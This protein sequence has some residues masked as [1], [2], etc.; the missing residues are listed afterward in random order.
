MIATAISRALLVLA[1]ATPASASDDFSARLDALWDFGDPAASETRF[2]AERAKHATGSREALETETQIARTQGLRRQFAAAHGTL[3]AVEPRLDA[4]DVRVRVRYLLERGRTFNSSGAPERAVPLFS[5][6]ATR[7]AAAGRASDEFYTVDALH[8]LG[9][10]APAADQLGWNLKALA[11]ADAATDPR[12]RGWRGSLLN[13]LGWTYFDAGNV[14]TALDYWRRALAF[15]EAAGNA[16]RIREAKWAV[17]RGL[18]AQGKL[19]EA[20][21]MQRALAAEFAASNETD[22]YVFEELAEIA[23]ARGDRAAAVPWA[24]KA[25]AALKDDGGLKANEPAR[26][27]RLAEIGGVAK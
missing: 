2:R 19:D 23:L 5:D 21:V 3:D 17:A 18:R 16:G 9:I 7:S 24:A 26:L 4:V 22:G 13:N 10:A 15:R 27:A 8:M 6:A 20:E 1:L 12:A 14:A 11:A 25:Y